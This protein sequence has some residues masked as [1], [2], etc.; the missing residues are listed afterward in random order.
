MSEPHGASHAARLVV[1]ALSDRD[2]SPAHVEYESSPANAEQ[3]PSARSSR[4]GRRRSERSPASE[5]FSLQ[6]PAGWRERC[7]A[8]WKQST[9]KQ[10]A[11]WAGC[12]V[13]ALLLVGWVASAQRRDARVDDELTSL[14]AALNHPA[15]EK[16][17][18]VRPQ[19]EQASGI[20]AEGIE[21]E[22]QQAIH[23]APADRGP[24]SE[25]IERVE[26]V[27]VQKAARGAVWLSG[28]IED[29]TESFATESGDH[30]RPGTRHP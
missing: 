25:Q 15:A 10:K 8:V 22:A 7:A 28:T 27:P 4:L 12:A 20:Q 6:E 16:T 1:P 2:A 3:E 19:I 9:I 13:A 24:E 21:P 17:P 14:T 18:V 23:F 26:F 30:V 29:G 11:T 5:Q